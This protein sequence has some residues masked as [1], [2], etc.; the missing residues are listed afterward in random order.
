ML[1]YRHPSQHQPESL[2]KE[3]KDLC[4]QIE[5]TSFAVLNVTIHSKM[6]YMEW[7]M[8]LI[9]KEDESYKEFIKEAFCEILRWLDEGQIDLNEMFLVNEESTTDEKVDNPLSEKF[10]CLY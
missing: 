5:Q 10:K 8:K 4:I 6:E 3:I 7:V 1:E 2:E 9:G